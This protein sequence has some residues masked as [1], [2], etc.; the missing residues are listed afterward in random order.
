M[1]IVGARINT[2][3]R[4]ANPPSFTFIADEYPEPIS[5][6]V[7]HLERNPGG[8]DAFLIVQNYELGFQNTVVYPIPSCYEG[9]NRSFIGAGRDYEYG[10]TDGWYDSGATAHKAGVIEDMVEVAV[11][12]DPRGGGVVYLAP[13]SLVRETM[14]KFTPEWELGDSF[15]GSYYHSIKRK[16]GE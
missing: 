4:F 10:L 12:K 14:A 7:Y 15:E 2:F 8:R 9:S 5:K 3:E 13:A 1:K 6:D 11:S 16:G